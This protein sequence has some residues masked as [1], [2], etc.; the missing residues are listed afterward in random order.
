MLHFEATYLTGISP[1]SSRLR[2]GCM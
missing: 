2:H 1:A